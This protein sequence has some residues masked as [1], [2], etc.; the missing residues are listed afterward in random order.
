MEGVNNLAIG[1]HRPVIHYRRLPW[2]AKVVTAC[3]DVVEQWSVVDAQL[4]PLLLT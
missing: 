4:S 3:R 2:T 1:A